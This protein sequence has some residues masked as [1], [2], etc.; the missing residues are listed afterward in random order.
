MSPDEGRGAVLDGET[1]ESA[2]LGRR[3]D[4]FPQLPLILGLIIVA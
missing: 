1:V 3:L 2:R 4:A